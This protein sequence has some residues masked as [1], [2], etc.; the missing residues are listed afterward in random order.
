M[1]RPST[2]PRAVRARLAVLV[3]AFALAAPPL[4]FAMAQAP[5]A[6]LTVVAYG[7]QRFDLAT[8]RTVLDDGGEVVDRASGVRMT[9]AW[10]AY[11]DGASL[12]AR[13]ATIAGDLGR[14]RAA[15]VVIDLELGRVRAE[16][17]LEFERP[18]IRARAA[19]LGLDGPAGLAWLA[20]GVVAE[21][22]D[23]TAAAVWIDVADGRLVL[24]GPFRYVDGPFVLEG[25]TGARLQLDPITVDDAAGYDARTDVE[26]DLV[27]RIASVAAALDPVP[28]TDP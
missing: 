20:G 11:V 13:D 1:Q 26:A 9:A 3:A 14:V 25:D 2:S 28:P 21:L 23:A 7:A 8:G 12:E 6:E 27:E 5:V 10:I 19:Y 18:G 16:G 24:D 17:D 15:R 22:P 4:P